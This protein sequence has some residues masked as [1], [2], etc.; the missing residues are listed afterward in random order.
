M[1]PMPDGCTSPFVL[2]RR[3]YATGKHEKQEKH[4]KEEKKRKSRNNSHHRLGRGRNRQCIYLA[5]L[6]RCLL[7]EW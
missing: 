1:S 7:H 3:D 6:A 4:E 5:F 2:I